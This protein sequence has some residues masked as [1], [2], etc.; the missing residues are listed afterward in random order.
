MK[1]KVCVEVETN[2]VPFETIKDQFDLPEHITEQ[3]FDSHTA[4]IAEHIQKEVMAEREENPIAS[5]NISIVR[6]K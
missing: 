5:L 2:D 3:N 1:L 4:E 6:R